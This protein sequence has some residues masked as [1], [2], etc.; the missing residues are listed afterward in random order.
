[1]LFA[2]PFLIAFLVAVCFGLTLRWGFLWRGVALTTSVAVILLLPLIVP[3]DYS[4]IRAAVVLICVFTVLKLCD[5]HWASQ[6]TGPPSRQAYLA[7]I[8]NFF[9]LVQRKLA[10]EVQPPPRQNLLCL[11]RGIV[12][13]LVSLVACLH[14]WRIDFTKIPFAAEHVIKTF[15]FMA[16]VYGTTAIATSIWRLPGWRARAHLHNFFLAQTP[17]EFWRRY[18]RVIGQFLYEDV[19]KRVGGRRAPVRATLLVF[20]LSGLIHEYAFG[21]VTQKL[22]GYQMAFFMIQGLA[23]VATQS[24]KPQGRSAVLW[25][26]STIAFNLATSVLFFASL[27]QF[28]PYWS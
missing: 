22:Q 11:S 28:W 24:I 16:L 10:N 2:A 15:S 7:F 3:A 13:S 19:F 12:I 18:S 26:I 27:N 9:T 21:I 23:V 14:I 17:A 25:T 5:V 20:A 6:L 1:M 4:I 8:V